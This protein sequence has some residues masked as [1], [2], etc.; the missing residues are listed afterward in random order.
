MPRLYSFDDTSKRRLRDSERDVLR[1]AVSR[2]M[3][4]GV[5]TAD[6]AAWMTEEGHVGT[7]GKPFVTMTL[8]R[9]FRNPAIA[10]C[11]Y[12]DDGELVDA[13]HPGSITREEF[14]DLQ[15]VLDPPDKQAADRAPA[16]D[17]MLT[18]GTSDC[19]YCAQPLT[20][21]R[22]N[23]GSPG[24]RCR[25][26]EK[27]GRGGCG[28]VRVDAVLLETYVAERVVAELLKPG[29][30]AKIEAARERVAKLVK[31]LGKEISALEQRRKD[32][33]EP[34]A[35]GEIRLAAFKEA[36]K[37]I[38]SKLKA[39]R[40]RLRYA[41]Q[42]ASFSMP[43]DTKDLVRWWN[44]APVGSRRALTR[45]LIEKVEL[46]S[47]SEQGVREVTTERVALHWRKLT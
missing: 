38:D 1:E 12:D 34:Y 21:S 5:S 18:S 31:D 26:A 32:L 30:R 28:K 44:R 9:L 25:P 42:M 36:H 37:E 16:Y 22:A 13:G 8:G 2:R 7:L 10:G 17:Y 45:L 20:G 40:S 35:L 19:G 43:E 3:Q 27:D 24:Y 4:P 11:R 14:E 6:V 46:F 29:I 41:E 23:S 39:L 33:A 47:A 15:K